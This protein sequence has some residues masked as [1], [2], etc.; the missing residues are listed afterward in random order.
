MSKEMLNRKMEIAQKTRRELITVKYPN[1]LDQLKEE[2]SMQIRR[3]NKNM[4]FTCR[5]IVYFKWEQKHG[6]LHIQLAFNINRYFLNYEEFR[7]WLKE[8]PHFFKLAK[9]LLIEQI[10]E[11]HKVLEKEILKC[12]AN[13]EF[14]LTDMYFHYWSKYR[15]TV[16]PTIIICNNNISIQ[17][18]VSKISEQKVILSNMHSVNDELKIDVPSD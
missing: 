15:N 6:R 2:S 4:R 14:G 13:S 1:I 10:Q 3:I 7:I 9:K 16:Y 17:E 12:K 8:F 11:N 18:I 5:R